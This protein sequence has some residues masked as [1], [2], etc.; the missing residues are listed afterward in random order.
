MRL[1]T[2]YASERI[3]KEYLDNELME[4]DQLKT[5]EAEAAAVKESKK[6]A[7]NGADDAVG[8]RYKLNPVYLPIA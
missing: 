4:K 8:R 1:G 7:D 3:C 2:A 6:K 5:A